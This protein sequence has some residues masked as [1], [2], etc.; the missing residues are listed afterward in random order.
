MDW[1]QTALQ[2][3][4]LGGVFWGYVRT[5]EALRDAGGIRDSLARCEAHFRLLDR[6]LSTQAYLGGQDLTL[7]DIP[8]GALL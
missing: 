3:D 8:A 4:F 6:I 2:P 1:A 7:A 5:P